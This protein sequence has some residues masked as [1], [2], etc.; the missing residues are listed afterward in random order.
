[1]SGWHTIL[2]LPGDRIWFDEDG[3]L[4]FYKWIN[5][6]F[7]ERSY[8]VSA[9]TWRWN[10]KGDNPIRVYFRHAKDATLFKLTWF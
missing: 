1:M 10:V 9:G 8:R 3:Y 2:E 4:I 6:T 7:G 5:D